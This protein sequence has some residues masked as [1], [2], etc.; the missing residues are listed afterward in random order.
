MNKDY[1]KILGVSETAS[2][3]EISKAFKKLAM[4]YHPDRNKGNKEAEAKFKEVNEA[5]SVLKDQKSREEYDMQRKYGFSGNRMHAGFTG[6]GFDD[7]FINNI[8]KGFQGSGFNF[9]FGFNRRPV[10]RDEH[11]TVNINLKDVLSQNEYVIIA[12]QNKI[13]IRIPKNVANGQTFRVRGAAVNNTNYDAGDLYVTVKLILPTR[14]SIVQGKL[15]Y[16]LNVDLMN[17]L[18]K[19]EVTIPASESIDGQELKIIIE[20]GEGKE[21]RTST[22]IANRGLYLG[23]AFNFGMVRDNLLV[24]IHYIYNKDK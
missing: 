12:G 3:S 7:D 21:L 5:Y 14:Y 10:G 19:T 17:T 9:D 11:V 13:Q 22:S 18:D 16:D 1:Y 2:E 23:M 15:T 4:Q 8:F 20:N 6:G 24:R